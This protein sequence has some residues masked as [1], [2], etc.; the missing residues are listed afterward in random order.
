MS[1]QDLEV[2]LK[3]DCLKQ[4]LRWLLAGISWCSV[5]FRDD[6]SYTPRLLACTAMLWAWSNES[7]LADRFEATRSIA[8]FLFSLQ[9]KLAGSYQAFIKLLHRW[10]SPLVALV[11][12]ALRQRMDVAPG[13][14]LPSGLS[15]S[16]SKMV[17]NGD[18]MVTPRAQK[19]FAK[20]GETLGLTR[21][22]DVMVAT[23]VELVEMAVHFRGTTPKAQRLRLKTFGAG[24][25]RVVISGG[26]ESRL[27]KS[28]I[29]DR[30]EQPTTDDIRAMF[31]HHRFPTIQGGSRMH[32]A[33]SQLMTLDPRQRTLPISYPDGPCKPSCTPLIQERADLTGE[34]FNVWGPNRVDVF[35]PGASKASTHHGATLPGNIP[36]VRPGLSRPVRVIIVSEVVSEPG[37]MVPDPENDQE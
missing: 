6:C 34:V 4:A 13:V 22:S 11:Q 9:H 20:Y 23:P 29:P 37:I 36:V 28:R 26:A 24:E 8:E 10:T 27:V 17:M 7:T 5:K 21:A 18:I 3:G 14:L 16:A 2:S 15:R 19:W 1:H 35:T 32:D 31:P 33:E 12:A 30:F 25:N